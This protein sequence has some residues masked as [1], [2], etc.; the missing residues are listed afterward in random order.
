MD[1]TIGDIRR[2]MLQFAVPVLIMTVL[3]QAYVIADNIIVSGFAGERDLSLIASASSLFGIGACLVNGAGSA[4]GILAA[5]YFG[6]HDHAGLKQ[7]IRCSF[8]FGFVLG[9]VL[10][11]GYLIG[12]KQMFQLVSLPQELRDDAYAVLTIYAIGLPIQ[13][14]CILIMSVLNGIGD[15]QTPMYNSIGTQA[16]NIL[17]D[18]ILVA[19]YHT[20]AKGAAWA[21]V[22]CLF[23]S[24]VIGL[25]ILIHHLKKL[26][27]RGEKDPEVNRRYVS[28]R[29]HPWF[30]RRSWPSVLSSFPYW[31]TV[32]V[33]MRSMV[34]L[35]HSM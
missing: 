6:A 5:G 9:A 19:E 22:F 15:A 29:F 2:K 25:A 34:I 27:G 30:S 13:A 33:W 4:G 7:G 17:L 23:L 26:E 14:L 35:Q 21:S 12:G 1:F 20:G 16:L 32:Q 31:S 10:L 18:Y 11:A 8:L 24:F 28:L 3:N